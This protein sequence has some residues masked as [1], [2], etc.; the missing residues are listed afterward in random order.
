M[1]EDRLAPVLYGNNPGALMPGGPW[2]TPFPRA[3]IL[4]ARAPAPAP[5]SPSD[6]RGR[7]YTLGAV[8]LVLAGLL[9]MLWGWW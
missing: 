6:S 7:L 1:G 3:P 9:A 2:R 5:P 8:L 4:P